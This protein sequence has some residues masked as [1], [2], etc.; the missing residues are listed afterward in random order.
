M[1]EI[2]Y[3][4][5]VENTHPLPVAPATAIDAGE[6]VML[7]AGEIVPV[8]AITDNLAFAGVARGAKRVEDTNVDKIVVSRP[9]ATARWKA[10]LDAATDIVVGD[11]L[12]ISDSKTLTKSAVDAIAEAVETKDDAT[13]VLVKFRI[14]AVDVG[15]AA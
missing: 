14:P 13:E 15:D 10:P 7:V 3:K 1:Y 8:A 5:G 9:N 2:E 4:D 12:A 11:L 6:L